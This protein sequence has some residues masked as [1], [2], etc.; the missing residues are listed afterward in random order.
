MPSGLLKGHIH[1]NTVEVVKAKAPAP[2]N[3]GAGRDDQNHC[4]PALQLNNVKKSDTDTL[5]YI[6]VVTCP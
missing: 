3:T 5:R 6:D 2:S 1:A 4:S